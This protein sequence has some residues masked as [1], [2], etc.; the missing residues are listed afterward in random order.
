MKKKIY[1]LPLLALICVFSIGCAKKTSQEPFNQYGVSFTYP[2]GWELDEAEELGAGRYYICVEKSGFNSSGILTIVVIEEE[3]DLTECL[4][5]FQEGIASQPVFSQMK[6]G[7]AVE[8]KYGQ[9][10][11][12]CAQYTAN[13][14][15][16]PHEGHMYV[17]STNGKTIYINEQEAVEDKSKNAAGFES[18]RESLRVE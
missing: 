15:S 14:A 17:F 11:G 6:M 4:A 8:G 16:M 2:S 1:L 18:L 5:D 13:V 9:Y 3:M 10:T 12:I 7:N